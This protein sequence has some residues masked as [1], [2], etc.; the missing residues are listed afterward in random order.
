MKTNLDRVFEVS[1]ILK[2]LDGLLEAI[3]GLILLVV[4]AGSIQ[5][6]ADWITVHELSHD[7]HDFLANHILHYTSHLSGYSVKFGAFYLLSH[8]IVKIVLVVAVLKQKLWAYP[9]MIGF[10]V[11]F[12]G[13]QIYRMSIHFTVGMLLLTLFD[14]FI[15]WLTVLE[16]KKHRSQHLS[17]AANSE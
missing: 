16:Y 15:V 10:L 6:F 5:R 17:T 3:G 11:V 14:V 8:G 4:S 2:G 7:P 1:I 9:W 12:I 13:Y